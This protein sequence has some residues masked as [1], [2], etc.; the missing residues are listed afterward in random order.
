MESN[1]VAEVVEI[2]EESEMQRM[3]ISSDMLSQLN[4]AIPSSSGE[5]FTQLTKD[6]V[7]ELMINIDNLLEFLP[8]EKI[9]ELS[10]QDFYHNY[11]KFLDD[12]EV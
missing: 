6:E 4:S 2:V 7:R 11:I 12:L 9:E 5:S 8:E 1:E 10:Q 3:G